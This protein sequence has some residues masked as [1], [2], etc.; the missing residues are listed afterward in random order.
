LGQRQA[1][2]QGYW[3]LR[4]DAA[5]SRWAKT[6]AFKSHDGGSINPFYQVVAVDPQIDIVK[7]RLSFKLGAR[8][9]EHAPLK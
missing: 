1:R 2:A 5:Q 9:P 8:E 6:G 4:S 3:K 7:A